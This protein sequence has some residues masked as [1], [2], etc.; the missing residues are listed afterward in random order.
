MWTNRE[1]L[2]LNSKVRLAKKVCTHA[3]LLGRRLTENI[4]KGKKGRLLEPSQLFF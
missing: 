4:P 1:E 3:K 2:V